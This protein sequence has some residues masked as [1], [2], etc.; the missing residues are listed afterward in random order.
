MEAEPFV[1]LIKSSRIVKRKRM[2]TA[3]SIARIEKKGRSHFK[4][5]GTSIILRETFKMK[6]GRQL[7]HDRF[8]W[9]ALVSK[10]MKHRVP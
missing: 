4:D 7:S 9:R 6:A 8:K 2:R 5:A 1:L 3:G 10:A